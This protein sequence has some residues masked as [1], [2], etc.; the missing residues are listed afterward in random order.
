MTP[1]QRFLLIS[2]ETFS[3]TIYNQTH[4][5]QTSLNLKL[6]RT[7]YK[8][9]QINVKIF[10]IFSPEAIYKTPLKNPRNTLHNKKKK[11]N[12]SQVMKKEKPREEN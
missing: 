11:T 2:Q 5:I 12:K 6:Q 1:V 4:F 3:G 10:I 9:S 8:G 7:F